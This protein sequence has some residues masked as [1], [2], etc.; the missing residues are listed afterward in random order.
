MPSVAVHP[1][2]VNY[3]CSRNIWWSLWWTKQL[4]A[5]SVLIRLTENQFACCLLVASFAVL[6]TKETCAPG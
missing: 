1:V 6:S 3:S 4:T 2:G 5:M